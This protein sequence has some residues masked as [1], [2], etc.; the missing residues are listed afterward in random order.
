[1]ASIEELDPGAITAEEIKSAQ[2][3]LIFPEGKTLSRE[4]IH[5]C[6]AWGIFQVPI[7]LDSNASNDWKKLKKETVLE[8]KE[9]L[10]P[11][12]CTWD[13]SHSINKEL[14]KNIIFWLAGHKD[15][16]FLQK[17]A[18]PGENTLSCS[19]TP[20]ND[21]PSVE[22][23]ELVDKE[24][25]LATLPDILQRLLEAIDD[26]KCTSHHLGEIIGNDPAL[27]AKILRL[28]N[29]PY[30]G[31]TNKVERIDRAITLVGINEI[32]KITASISVIS[33]FKDIPQYIMDMRS[34]WNHS[35]G[36]GLIAETLAEI[37]GISPQK[38]M[39]AGILHDI[40]R[41]ILLKNH[42]ELMFYTI[43]EAQKKKLPL[44][45]MEKPLWGFDHCELGGKIISLWNFPHFLLQS[46]QFHH[47]P[48]KSDYPL[49]I[50][51]LQLAD[52]LIHTLFIG[53]SGNLYIPPVPEETG[54][55]LKINPS[56]I[57]G[58]F[59]QTQFKLKEICDL[60]Q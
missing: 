4:D 32:F 23:T 28:V 10:L 38:M 22:L 2:G 7:S 39:L 9:N 41:L 49:E 33:M 43:R 8:Y 5:K 58:V 50:G 60:I 24:E 25:S 52:V 54:G 17:A 42:P 34:F 53:T 59:T 13:F 20:P 57:P 48:H 44:N 15:N 19:D 55:K 26:P 29:S 46:V 47:A 30:F 3:R 21:L 12:F 31:F 14:F 16:S 51:I 37:T 1:M 11:Y 45:Q 56:M 36:C 18:F 27:T 35:I 40:G 6:K